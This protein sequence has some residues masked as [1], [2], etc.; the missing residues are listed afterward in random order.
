MFCVIIGNNYMEIYVLSRG[1][2]CSLLC[3]TLHKI[4][5]RGPPYEK[6]RNS[7][8]SANDDE[9]RLKKSNRSPNNATG[10]LPNFWPQTATGTAVIISMVKDR[11][12]LS[13]LFNYFI[14]ECGPRYQDNY[15]TLRHIKLT[16]KLRTLDTHSLPC[17]NL[18]IKFSSSEKYT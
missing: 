1:I 18:L 13:H 7:I 11:K 4:L 3:K 12:F 5:P 15:G 14:T 8:F 2:P 17:W 6:N 9:I 10:R 16:F